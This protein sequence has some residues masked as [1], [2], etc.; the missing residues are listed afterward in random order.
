MPAAF[1]VDTWPNKPIT[2]IVPFPPGG[3]TD[4]L[5]RL[6]AQRLSERLG[7]PVIVDNRPGAGGNLG[8]DLAAKASPDGYTLAFSTSGPLANNK[9][10]YKSLPFDPVANLAP[11]AAIGEIPVVIAV[12]PSSKAKT[13]KQFI[14]L[15]HT[16]PGKL[17]VGNPG[18]GT[19]GHLVA[20]LVRT[21]AKVDVLGVPYRGDT[22]AMADVL[23]GNIDAVCMP[24]T[25]LIPNVQ[26]GKV[27]ALAVTSRK[28]SPA[29]PDVPTTAEQGVDV[30]ATVW[31]AVVGP[32][33]ISSS[34][35]NRLNKEINAIISTPDAI[36]KL[37]Q[38][39]ATPI[40]GTAQQLAHL[41]AADSAKWKQV[42]ESAHIRID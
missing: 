17:A 36:A 3:A 41:M 37:A 9:Y 29:L 15:A 12:P 19:I 1:A 33:G 2:L 30:D 11:V 6:I 34:T 35:I 22:P 32:S 42:I 26:A 23:G 31:F 20:E 27:K 39:G 40:G 13:L 4:A 16:Q 5:A 38:F 8:T 10:L 28:R 25:S 18:N 24:I 14:E 7:K 21:K